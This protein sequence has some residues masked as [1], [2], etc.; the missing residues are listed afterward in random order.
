MVSSE[1]LFDIDELQVAYI[2]ALDR[3]DMAGWLGCFASEASYRCTTAENE[4]QNLPVSIMLDDCSERLRDRV[5]FVNQV[6]QGTFEPYQTRHLVQRLV[7]EP[8]GDRIHVKSNVL[9]AYTSEAGRSDL[10]ASGIYV[11]EVIRENGRLCFAA[12]TAVL[13]TTVTPRY[14]VYPI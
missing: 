5:K 13:D 3:Q 6:W 10:L 2:S 12:K 9:V 11:D 4:I 8:D 14:L 1:E 7:V